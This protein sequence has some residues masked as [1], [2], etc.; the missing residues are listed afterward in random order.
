[1]NMYRTYCLLIFV[2]I[3]AA[4]CG[5]LERRPGSDATQTGHHVPQWTWSSALPSS[6]ARAELIPLA[7][8]RNT[9]AGIVDKE[10]QTTILTSTT[11]SDPAFRIDSIAGQPVRT[12]DDLFAITRRTRRGNHTIP[13]H[14]TTS[15]NQSTQHT[16][17]AIATVQTTPSEELHSE[18]A[19]GRPLDGE[20]KSAGTI[21]LEYDR[22]EAIEHCIARQHKAVRMV[23]GGNP[24][25]VVPAGPVQC[26]LT[27]RVERVSGLLQVIVGLKVIDWSPMRLPVEV[28]ASCE[29]EPLQCLTASEA[30]EVLYGDPAK[31]V[32][33][34]PSDG[35]YSFI[36]VSQREDYQ[37]PTNYR[38]LE[39]QRRS[40]AGLPAFA[41]ATGMVYPGSPL[42][43][44]ARALAGF[45]LQPQLYEKG[46]PEQIGWILFGG[47]SLRSGQGIEIEIDLGDGRITV[48]FKVPLP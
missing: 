1:M 37:I 38:R 12:L 6:T 9:L 2:P 27:A 39:D 18:P 34:E 8:D 5:S 23:E 7:I 22:L 45:M 3:V 24:W 16:R 10:D 43:G 32:A 25:V 4:S 48:P 20:N 31:R 17:P 30:L 19:S 36:A 35:V 46:Q 21:A 26:K 41:R 11:E 33:G 15:S 28:R 42:L 47:E 40:A 14:V 44:D 29:N 13:I